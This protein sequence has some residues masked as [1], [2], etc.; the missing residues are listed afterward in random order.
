MPTLPPPVA[1]VAP[2]A[3]VL[4]AVVLVARNAAAVGVE[5]ETMAPVE[6]VVSI[7]L[8]PVPERVKD[9]AENEEVSV[10]VPTVKFPAVVEARYELTA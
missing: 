9:G 4:V 7:M 6:L 10:R 3:N 1:N 2:P 8:A 5:E